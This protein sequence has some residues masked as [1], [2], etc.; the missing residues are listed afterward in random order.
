MS[1]VAVLY[2]IV[3]AGHKLLNTLAVVLCILSKVVIAH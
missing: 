1:S 2:C 3:T